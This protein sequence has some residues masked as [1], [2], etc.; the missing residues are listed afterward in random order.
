MV[1]FGSDWKIVWACVIDSSTLGLFW[2][3]SFVSTFWH[4]L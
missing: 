1:F 2:K 4:L 3:N